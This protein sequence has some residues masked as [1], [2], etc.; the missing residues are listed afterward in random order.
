MEHMSQDIK[1]TP[2][3]VLH[4]GVYN[5]VW[6]SSEKRAAFG[7]HPIP[8]DEATQVGSTAIDAQEEGITVQLP[9]SRE[10]MRV[11]LGRFFFGSSIFIGFSWN[12]G[13]QAMECGLHER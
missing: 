4:T 2:S 3:G 13:E 12:F 7:E 5:L 10:W 1:T 8:A 9:D 6:G 11:D